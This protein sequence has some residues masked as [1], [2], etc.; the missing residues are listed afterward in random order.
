MIQSRPRS[1]CLSLAS[2]FV[3]QG[4]CELGWSECYPHS[5]PP[6]KS[7]GDKTPT[8]NK[9]SH[10][11]SIVKQNLCFDFENQ[12]QF[13]NYS[14]VLLQVICQHWSLLDRSHYGFCLVVCSMLVVCSAALRAGMV[15]T[16]Y[17]LVGFFPRTVL[18]NAAG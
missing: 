17:R 7:Q 15:M 16:N 6:Q 10:E 3:S 11:T 14:P 2:K 18:E 8:K 13:T 4:L 12:W 5:P 9:T 1:K